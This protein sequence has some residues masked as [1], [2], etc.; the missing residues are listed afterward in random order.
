MSHLSLRTVRPHQFCCSERLLQ[1]IDEFRPTPYFKKRR[2]AV[3]QPL[4]VSWPDLGR[5][6]PLVVKPVA[7]TAKPFAVVF[8]D[9]KRRYG[10]CIERSLI[11][12]I[13]IRHQDPESYR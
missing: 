10:A 2:Q 12:F 13:A 4:R 6:N 9:F 8:G 11:D 7:N 5:D 1:E 3:L